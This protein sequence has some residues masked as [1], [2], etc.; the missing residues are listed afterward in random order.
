MEKFFKYLTFSL[1]AALIV[2]ASCGGD[3]DDDDNNDTGPDA[4]D[5]VV[6]DLISASWVLTEGGATLDNVGVEGWEGFTLTVTGDRNSLSYGTGNSADVAVW[7]TGGTWEFI[8]DDGRKVERSDGIEIDVT[9][10]DTN[11]TLG[12]D[13]VAGRVKGIEGRWSF[14]MEAQ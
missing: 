6:E 1:F 5:L 8:G 14:N 12:F 9:V 4:I 3:D 10:S 13:I 7:P 11:L 2:F